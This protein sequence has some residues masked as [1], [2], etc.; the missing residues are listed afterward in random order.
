MNEFIVYK[1]KNKINGKVYIGMTC[2]PEQRWHPYS[3]KKC[4]AFYAAI[5]K[6]G[7]ENFEHIIIADGLTKKEAQQ[8]EVE[9]IKAHNSR[10][11]ECGYNLGNG[12]EC[13]ALG[14]KY[15][16]E[17][18]E[19]LSEARKGK[20]KGK[21]VSTATEFKKGHGFSEEALTKM[22][23]AKL[24]K[25]PWNKGL[26]G[27]CAGE[28]NCMK[29]PEVAQK[30]KGTNN[31]NARAIVQYSLDGEKVKEWPYISAINE[32]YGWYISNIVKCCRNKI[33]SAYGYR[34]VYSEEA[35]S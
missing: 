30:H 19:R 17:Q 35:A 29:R 14:Y 11:R 33:K 18:R 16:S 27:F 25:T 3:Y 23:L 12:G 10:N 22:R 7:W 6:Y 9:Q 28:K 5:Q 13:N 8:L 32:E 26:V 20:G 34:W 2:R 1:H 31:A 21:H 4:P 24:G 15:T